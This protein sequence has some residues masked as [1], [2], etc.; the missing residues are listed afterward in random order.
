MTPH[1]T[2]E[3]EG[4]TGAVWSSVKASCI[5]AAAILYPGDNPDELVSMATW[6]KAMNGNTVSL[7]DVS[8]TSKCRVLPMHYEVAAYESFHRRRRSSLRLAYRLRHAAPQGKCRNLSSGP[9]R[10]PGRER[11]HGDRKST[12][13]NSSH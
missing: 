5:D 2:E 6:T 1:L 13:L 7:G 8:E 10:R 4:T 9:D 12:S 3:T 11:H